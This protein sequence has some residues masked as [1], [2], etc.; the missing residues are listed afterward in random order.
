MRSQS[1]SRVALGIGAAAA[2]LAGCS[3]LQPPIG[4]PGA[5]AQTSIVAARAAHG[6]SWMLPEASSDDLL[7]LSDEHYIYVYSYPAGKLVGTLT[8]YG[9]PLYECTDSK[10][11]V[12]V[13]NPSASGQGVYEYAH[14]GSQPINYFAVNVAWA[15]AVDPKTGNLA[16]IP[17]GGGNVYIFANAS[18][19]PTVY[20]ESDIYL[21]TGIAYDSSGNLFVVGSHSNR[22]FAFIE[23]PRGSSNFQ[24]VSIQGSVYNDGSGLLA[25]DGKYLALG[26]EQAARRQR[27]TTEVANRIK[28]SGSTGTVVGKVPLAQQ[29]TPY[30]PQFRIFSK[31]AIDE[32]D[33]RKSSYFAY[34]TYPGAK[35]TKKIKLL[36]VR[37][38]V[39]VA[40]S[41]APSR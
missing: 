12:F 3:G 32:S 6:G 31:T 8:G 21:T 27:E 17:E 4:T 38:I 37:G 1:L 41:L 10:G 39:G 15:C 13:A 25:W 34:F 35:E 29:K 18:G 7:Y 23:L 16:I 19:T 28:I 2:L 14:G 26:S 24:N 36:D 33:G 30:H 5:M 9:L 40:L 11:D 20:S 22:S